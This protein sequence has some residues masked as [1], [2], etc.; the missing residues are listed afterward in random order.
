MQTASVALH[1][2]FLTLLSSG[3]SETQALRLL[4]FMLEDALG[5]D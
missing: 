2:M 1:E 5:E 4:G 3:F